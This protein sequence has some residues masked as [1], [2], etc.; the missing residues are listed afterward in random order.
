MKNLGINR[1]GRIQ[2]SL[3]IINRV[4]CGLGGCYFLFYLKAFPLFDV[5]AYCQEA[6]MNFGV[7]V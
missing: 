4:I 6:L 3:I 7:L 2:Y 5:S 1:L